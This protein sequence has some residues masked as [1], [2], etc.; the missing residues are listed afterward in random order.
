V[1]GGFDRYHKRSKLTALER[2]ALD[3][4]IHRREPVRHQLRIDNIGLGLVALVVLLGILAALSG[5]I[6]G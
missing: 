6:G 1:T 4:W 3:A 2:A 5:S